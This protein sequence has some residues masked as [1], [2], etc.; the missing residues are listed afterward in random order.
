MTFEK[1]E[2]MY[3][4]PN[5]LRPW[6]TKEAVKVKR[7]ED[8]FDYSYLWIENQRLLF[9]RPSKA[10]NG[11][12]VSK[13]AGGWEPAGEPTVSPK[14]PP[15]Y[16]LTNRDGKGEFEDNLDGIDRI[17][18][19]ILDRLIVAKHQAHRSRAIEGELEETDEAGNS[20]DYSEMFVNAPGA[21]WELPPGVK[22]WESQTTDIMPLLAAVKDDI[23]ELC[24]A[25]STP[26]GD[27]LPDGANVSA[28]GQRGAREGLIFKTMDR[29]ARVNP[30]VA[31][32]VGDYMRIGI[33]EFDGYLEVEWANPQIHPG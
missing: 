15:I 27:M 2:E 10:K 13:I 22:I 21:F 30:V 33:P 5:P 25:T 31:V 4:E 17:H 16:I 12:A 29:I 32:A 1:A 28:E 7:G 11:R 8:G 14:I 24:A 26:V 6:L 19:G 23:R 20:I 18:G 9:R 3:A